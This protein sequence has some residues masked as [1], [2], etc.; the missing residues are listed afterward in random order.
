MCAPIND[1]PLDSNPLI[2]VI[3]PTA[4]PPSGLFDIAK[5]NSVEP[6]EINSF[7]SVGVSVPL[8]KKNAT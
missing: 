2:S 7:I 4:I 6:V 1:F 3:L 8:S 5:S